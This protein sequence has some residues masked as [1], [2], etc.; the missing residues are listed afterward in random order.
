MRLR[1]RERQ[2][3][4]SGQ[5]AGAAGILVIEDSRFYQMLME[6][7]IEEKLGLPVFCAS[8]LSDA[9]GLLDAL[10]HEPAVVVADLNLPDAQGVETIAALSRRIHCPV[11]VLTGDYSSR[12]R[13][14]AGSREIF[15]YILKR[16]QWV[17]DELINSISRAVSNPQHS[18]LI[19]DD[20]SSSRRSMRQALERQFLKVFEA[21]DGAKGL[22]TIAAR[23]ELSLVLLDYEMPR[24]NGFSF[25]E[26]MRKDYALDD[27][28]VIGVSSH[29]QEELTIGFL[30]HGANDFI[31]KPFSEEEFIWRVNL[32]LRLVVQQRRLQEEAF[33]DDLS[34]LS[35]RRHFF[36]GIAEW[37]ESQTPQDS[38]LV[39]MIDI[40]H[41]KAVNDHYGHLAGDRVIQNLGLLL[42]D[43]FHPQAL[44]ARVGGEEFAVIA[45][46]R[47]I[48][49]D[50]RATLERLMEAVRR[51][52]VVF[53]SIRLEYRISLAG[54]VFSYPVN[55]EAAL[56]EIDHL[57]YRAKEEGRDRLVWRQ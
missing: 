44:T 25:L 4:V 27:L 40:D 24:M 38:F 14:L 9:L 23:P 42:K 51:Q 17:M 32:N 21:E 2:K 7:S 3:T 56:Q 31:R 29:D 45:P 13:E 6:K 52:I 1:R 39:V 16:G 36:R 37:N 50:V 47:F 34:G 54:G 49:G 46:L 41:F 15:D 53:Q 10:P 19:V 12:T 22:E 55:F 20:S 33:L 11:I 28:A 5:G 30:K 43:T 57:L 35:N 8:S 26:E 18:V 48:D